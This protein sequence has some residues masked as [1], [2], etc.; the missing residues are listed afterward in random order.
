MEAIPLFWKGYYQGFESLLDISAKGF[1]ESGLGGLALGMVEGSI[2]L[3]SM[4][5]TGAMAGIYQGIRG[6]ERTLGA[7]RATKNGM[8][9]DK[10]LREWFYYNLDKEAQSVL[11]DQS[12][13]SSSKNSSSHRRGNLRRR[14]KESTFYDILNVQ[15]DATKP[16]IKKAYYNMALTIHP[17]KSDDLSAE[18]QF[19]Q[20]NSIY[21]I[22]MS[23]DSRSLYDEHGSCYVT[24]M[25][26]KTDSTAQVDPYIF[27][28]TLFGSHV[29]EL[30]VGD[31]GISS[32]VD[33]ILLLTERAD[34][35]Y[36]A[37]SKGFWY[38]S[39]QQVRR[40]VRIA[41]HLRSRIE[42]YVNDENV[43][44]EEF[45]TSCTY[46]ADA[47]ASSL[48]DNFR[49]ESLLKG[50]ASGLIAESIEYLVAPMFRPMFGSY[51]EIKSLTHNLRVDRDL[52][53]AVRKAMMKYSRQT[54]TANTH[55]EVDDEDEKTNT[56]DDCGGM[57]D[58]GK[59]L[60]ALLQ[61]M[62]AP[63]MWNVLLDFNVND[64]ARTVREASRRVLYDCGPEKQLRLK[65]A[66]ALNALGRAFHEAFQRQVKKSVVH[67]KVEMTAESIH[68][69][70][71]AALLESVVRDS[72]FK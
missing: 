26:E 59:D 4:T 3:V 67:D 33:N 15:P 46:E 13:S 10:R 32:M 58:D 38:E 42:S 45:Q 16:Q 62:S 53:R 44:L 6:I 14:V 17:D 22:L 55:D 19:R 50:I 68:E 25:S 28:S 29:V 7:I 61:A 63:R 12:E 34:T 11:S 27:F 39:A 1:T 52:E 54:S 24:Q 31:L 36:Q 41:S 71:K 23:D 18:E 70:V 56:R 30:Y 51:F 65:K 72:V 66:T 60:D 69:K 40:Q 20:L 8:A 35:Q 2:H 57:D 9:W 21:K 37:N 5:A 47:L 64:V 49:T 48:R 43:T